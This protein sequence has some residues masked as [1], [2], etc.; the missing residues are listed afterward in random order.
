MYNSRMAG[1]YLPVFIGD[2]DATGDIPFPCSGIL[3]GVWSGDNCMQMHISLE[4]I[5]ALL[6]G[7]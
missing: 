5:P 2:G 4:D 3:G 1:I 7:I 6:S